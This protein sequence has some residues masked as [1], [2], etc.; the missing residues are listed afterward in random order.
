MKFQ[1]TTLS[2]A[3]L[4]SLMI[5]STGCSQKSQPQY[6]SYKVKSTTS[7]VE[8]KS[9]VIA[10]SKILQ[11][12]E[13]K[14]FTAVNQVKQDESVLYTVTLDNE[15]NTQATITLGNSGD[16]PLIINSVK[17]K[18]KSGLLKMS[19]TCDQPLAGK[20]IC[21]VK[22]DFKTQNAGEYVSYLEIISNDPKHKKS[23]IS[24]NMHAK[25]HFHAKVSS[26]KA[27]GL[28]VQ[29]PVKL[30][31][32]A[33]DRVHYVEIENDG[34]EKIK[35]NTPIKSGKDAKSFSYKTDC[36]TSLAVG[37]KCKVA[38]TY[39]PT[40]KE[41]FSDANMI[42]PSNAKI[43]PSNAIRL[44]GYSK[45]FSLQITNFVVSKNISN[46]VEDYF[47][48]N[49][50]YYIRTIYQNNIGRFFEQG[51]REE[52]KKYFQ[53]NNFK[54]VSSADKADKVIT[55]YPSINVQKND[56]TNDVQYTIVINGFATTK[57]KN[58][59][60]STNN[61]KIVKA[62]TPNK[63]A[64]FQF[65][66]LSINE[67]VIPEYTSPTSGLHFS[68]LTLNDTVFSKEQFQF[69]VTVSV[70]NIT[71]EKEVDLTIADIVVS[72]LFNVL[73]LQ[74]TKGNN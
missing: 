53:V 29:K 31:F 7:Q 36:Q 42:L 21:Q 57:S 27:S 14:V 16:K 73:G 18:D 11:D 15:K 50:T 1:K 66:A 45:P 9:K 17:L 34:I 56:K 44:E 61:K 32:N 6:K 41:G 52:I 12:Q 59:K 58:I 40:K 43:T 49:K 54:M 70:D 55:I 5:F 62:F 28:N 20:E 23:K 24:I 10:K 48:S 67:K 22:L 72:K 33:G 46:F 2:L 35:L 25:S 19:S 63:D 26:I 3:T 13:L 47:K 68:A 39:D 37:E 38:I 65:S 64:R 51:V 8:T 30:T 71:D 60:I 69:G 4:A 74:D